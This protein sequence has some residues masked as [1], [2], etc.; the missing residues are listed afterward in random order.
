VTWFVVQSLLVI[1]PAFALG[2]LVGWLWWGRAPQP[3]PAVDSAPAVPV[4]VPSATPAAVQVIDLTEG[5]SVPHH[6][7]LPQGEP[8]PHHEPVPRTDDGASSGPQLSPAGTEPQMLAVDLTGLEAVPA[9]VVI[10]DV[11]AP[12][13]PAHSSDVAP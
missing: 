10:G 8:A 3:L 6:E 5:G 1:I 9:E 4:T 13:P 11:A 2:V 12:E 7:P